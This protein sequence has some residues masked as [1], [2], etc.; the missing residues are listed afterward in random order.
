[1]VQTKG[2][3]YTGGRF[4]RYSFTVPFILHS[5]QIMT[6][7]EDSECRIRPGT[8]PEVVGTPLE[9]AVSGPEMTR[10]TPEATGSLRPDSG[11]K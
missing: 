8:G 10:K 9:T 11:R 5:F 6:Q 7:V 1:M 2:S 3:P 4:H